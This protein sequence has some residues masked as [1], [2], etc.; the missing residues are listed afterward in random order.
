MSFGK[1]HDYR[2]AG[3]GTEAPSYVSVSFWMG[4]R[5]QGTQ[6]GTEAPSYVSLLK[7]HG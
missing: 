7:I 2:A 4:T 1:G 6:T 3:T 5:P